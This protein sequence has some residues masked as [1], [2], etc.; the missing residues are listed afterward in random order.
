MG[1]ID[2]KAALADI[3]ARIGKL[4]I[5]FNKEEKKLSIQTLDKSTHIHYHNEIGLS[6]EEI[7]KLPAQDIGDLVKHKAYLN[8]KAAFRDKP[9][10][11][12]KYYSM[13]NVAA[14]TTGA[15]ILTA[16]V[17]VAKPVDKLILSG[18][19]IKR[20][21][22]AIEASASNDQI[23]VKDIVWLKVGER[24]KEKGSV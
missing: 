13:Y 24:N 8:I 14:L 10:Q 5:G 6:D 4:N 2:I 23:S 16:E 20:L 15:T 9:E 19:F 7:L 12:V 11:M 22:D 18:D 1:I 21:P 17:F 3:K